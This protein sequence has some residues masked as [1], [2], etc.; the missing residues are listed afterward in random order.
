[1]FQQ[2]F[3]HRFLNTLEHT[4]YGSLEVTMPDGKTYSFQGIQPGAKADWHIIDWRTIAVFAAKGD[5]GLTEAYRDGWWDTKDLPALML[6][7]LQNEEALDDYLYGGFFS[8]IV[9]RLMYMFSQNSL[10][11]SR[12]NIQAHYDLGNDFYKLWLDPS[13]SYSSALFK[14]ENESLEHAQYNKYD[15]ILEQLETSSGSL[16]E[17][18]CGWGGMAERATENSD[19]DVRG[20]TLSLQQHDYA[21]Q[22]LGDKAKIVLED[23]RHQDGKFDHIVSIEMF[24]AVGEK[25][26]PVYFNKLQS[27]LKEKGKAIIQ[28]ITIDE[29]YFERYRQG[30]DMI[31]SFIFPGGMLPTASRFAYEAKQAGLK[32]CD[33]HSFGTDYAK[34]LKLW[35]D[36]FDS[37]LSH[38]RELQ[39]DDRFIRVWR[40]YLS[41][42]MA[43]FLVGR[44]N[45]MQIELAHA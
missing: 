21:T 7:G 39:F 22:R 12:R 14:D 15:R 34:T 13:M 40:F 32:V 30:G 43:S 41:A 10:R 11:G 5:I 35:L 17:I 38:I 8:S 29:P 2:T 19:F 6:F 20:I 33:S 42:C 28:T 1:M 31:R 25:Y 3:I 16:L 9:T 37:K 26:W 27:L 44:T 24:E 36:E 23:Y 18:G 45:V 4:Q